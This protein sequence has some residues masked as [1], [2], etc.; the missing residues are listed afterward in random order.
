MR[1][2][3]VTAKSDAAIGGRPNQETWTWTRLANVGS[4]APSIRADVMGL[5]PQPNTATVVMAASGDRE[6]LDATS[7]RPTHVYPP[8]SLRRSMRYATT[9]QTTR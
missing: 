4:I 9:R 5:G 1:Q 7:A 8:M 6:A 3:A 2:L